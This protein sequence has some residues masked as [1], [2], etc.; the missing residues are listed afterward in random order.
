MGDPGRSS[1]SVPGSSPR[2]TALR[3]AGRGFAGKVFGTERRIGRGSS[4]GRPVRLVGEFELGGYAP[5]ALEIVVAA[6]VLPGKSLNQTP[7]NEKGP[8]AGVMPLPAVRGAAR[9]VVDVC[10]SSRAAVPS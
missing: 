4:G 5:E 8:D 2:T 3:P 1:G 10:R 7:Q 6:G 9:A